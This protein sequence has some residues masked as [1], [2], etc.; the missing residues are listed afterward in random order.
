MNSETL[1]LRQVHPLFVQEGRVTSQVFRPT[2]KDESLLSTYNGDM[3]SPQGAFEHY[4]NKPSCQSFGVMAVT[5]CECDTHDLPVIQDGVPFPEHV[6]I[7]FSGKA[8]SAIE[9]IAKLLRN[10]AEQRGW[11]YR[12]EAGG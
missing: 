9:R 11:L 10:V 1:L 5:K 4:T 8:K 2:P 6:S 7:D 3:I 12:A